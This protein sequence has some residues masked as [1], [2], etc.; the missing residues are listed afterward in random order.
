MTIYMN[1][2]L[3]FLL[4]IYLRELPVAAASIN[5]SVHHFPNCTHHCHPCLPSLRKHLKAPPALLL[6]FMTENLPWQPV[7]AVAVSQ[8]LDYT[9]RVTLVT[10]TF[11]RPPHIQWENIHRHQTFLLLTKCGMT[12]FLITGQSFRQSPHKEVNKCLFF[13]LFFLIPY[14]LVHRPLLVCVWILACL[15]CCEGIVPLML[16]ILKSMDAR[17]NRK[18]LRCSGFHRSFVGSFVRHFWT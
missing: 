17:N 8:A 12:I 3:Y 7:D 16:A 6:Q 11:T 4:Q 10:P 13:F 5:L 15:D 9:V 14:G 2:P 1:F 18:C